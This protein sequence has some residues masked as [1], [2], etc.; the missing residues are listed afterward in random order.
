MKKIDPK[1][2][3]I[4]QIIET[5]TSLCEQEDD[6]LLADERSR[7]KRLFFRVV[8]LNDEL[9]ARGRDA[10][11]ALK[12]LL[13]H[14]NPQVRLNAAQDLLAVI[15]Q[16]ARSIL[17]DLRDSRAGPQCLDAGMTLWNLDRGVFT[18]D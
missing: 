3:T 5:Y 14:R 8:A 17:Q 7:Y 15:P 4:E 13:Q 12:P 2:M 6:A 18:P 9:K 10:R 16:E 1:S 11:L